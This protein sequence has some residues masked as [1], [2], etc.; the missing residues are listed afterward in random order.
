[1]SAPEKKTFARLL[2]EARLAGEQTTDVMA[3]LLNITQ[4]EYEL[5]ESGQYPD[6]ETLRRIC[7]LLGWNYYDTQRLLIN[8]M[9][10]PRNL[11]RA[12]A[13]GETKPKAPPQLSVPGAAE[14]PL[15]PATPLEH[16]GAGS[17]T[18][19]PTQPETLGSRLREVRL[20]TGQSVDVIAM[21]LNTT[22]ETYMA[23][24]A[25]ASPSD[26]MLRRIS[27]V[28]RWNY[29]E[30]LNLL[31]TEHAHSFQPVRVGTP[32]PAATADLEKLKALN[33]EVQNIFYRMTPHDRVRVLAQIELIRDTMRRDLAS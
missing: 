28:Y 33:Q 6:D 14:L 24:E 22:A 11:A 31:R 17:R 19:R 3:V 1:M 4:E 5:L 30:L 7:T 8:E 9:I 26:E 32:Y 21:L 27:S 23:L 2:Q 10:A 20:V 15:P 18:A 25:G 12:P 13:K 16:V 29:Q